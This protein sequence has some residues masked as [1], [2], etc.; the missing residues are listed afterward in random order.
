MSAGS[1]VP[2]SSSLATPQHAF[3][4][5]GRRNARGVPMQATT[6]FIAGWNQSTW[7][8]GASS[9]EATGRGRTVRTARATGREQHA[10]TAPAAQLVSRSLP[11]CGTA[12]QEPN[13]PHDGRRRPTTPSASSDGPTS[14][15]SQGACSCMAAGSSPRHVPA[16]AL[17]AAGALFLPLPAHLRVRLFPRVGLVPTA[18]EA[19][20]Q[21]ERRLLLDV[22]VGQRAAVLQ[23]LASEDQA[24]LVGRDALLVLDLGLDVLDR[25]RRLDLERDR[26]T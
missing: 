22:V 23:L 8:A 1:D 15:R 7:S 19:Q 4:Q 14:L 3:T 13:F 10:C 6:L 20:H 24:L 16:L 12:L 17:E 9:C 5:P 11:R 18:T 25:V 21:V 2:A 26:L